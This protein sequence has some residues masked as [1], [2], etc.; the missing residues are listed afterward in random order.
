[1][2]LARMLCRCVRKGRWRIMGV[3]DE[4]VR[5]GILLSVVGK[6]W[7]LES[8]TTSSPLELIAPALSHT[9][10]LTS[11]SHTHSH[12]HTL[13][14]T[15]SHTLSTVYIHTP[16]LAG[17]HSLHLPL[18]AHSSQ[19]TDHLRADQQPHFRIRPQ[20]HNNNNNHHPQAQE[21]IPTRTRAGQSRAKQ[22]GVE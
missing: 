16:T 21:Q 17:C 12:T 20:H 15:L 10:A 13:S 5:R 11:F 9:F 2:D 19:P 18:I 4:T 6:R 14:L 3:G 22:I 7:R 1:M 8:N